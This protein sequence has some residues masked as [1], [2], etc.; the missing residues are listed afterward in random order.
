MK[1]TKKSLD[2]VITLL[3]A[4]QI[5]RKFNE[6]HSVAKMDRETIIKWALYLEN[7]EQEKHK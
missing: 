4:E 1:K 5:L 7:L 3:E 6:W 2:N